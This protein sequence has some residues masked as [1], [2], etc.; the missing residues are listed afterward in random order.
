MLYGHLTSASAGVA[1]QEVRYYKRSLTGGR[2]IYVG[3]SSSAA[4]TGWH[5]L[6]VHPLIARVWKVVYA[7]NTKLLPATSSYLTV[8]PR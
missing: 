4:P 2:W 6:V 3:R 1:K 7:G 5:S 8:R